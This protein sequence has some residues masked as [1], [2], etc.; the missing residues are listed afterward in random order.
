M[1][2]LVARDCRV[3]LPTAALRTG[4]A[5]GDLK[6][7]ATHVFCCKFGDYSTVF[8]SQTD[9][10][11]TVVVASGAETATKMGGRDA[12]LGDLLA[13]KL[14]E[15]ADQPL[16]LTLAVRNLE[17]IDDVKALVALYERAR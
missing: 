2:S 7:V 8:V 3:E 11:G 12:P 13:R 1:A 14:S 15:L 5:S 16:V 10:V 9:G 6:G 4:S 17:T